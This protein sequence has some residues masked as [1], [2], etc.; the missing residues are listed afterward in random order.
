MIY[1]IVPSHCYLRKIQLQFVC[2]ARIRV[3]CF[4]SLP[5]GTDPVQELIYTALETD[6]I[7]SIG[8][9]RGSFKSY[10]LC[11][12]YRFPIVMFS[13]NNLTGAGNQPD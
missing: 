7:V 10:R 1:C 9:C 8:C 13:S 5:G 4:G 12:G 2:I 6:E 3:F 11:K